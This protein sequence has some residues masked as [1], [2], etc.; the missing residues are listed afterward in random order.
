MAIYERVGIDNLFHDPGIDNLWSLPSKPRREIESSADLTPKE[1]D[2]LTEF[3]ETKINIAPSSDIVRHFSKEI[4]AKLEFANEPG[5]F[6]VMETQLEILLSKKQQK[7]TYERLMAYFSSEKA[8]T[9][10]KIPDYIESEDWDLYYWMLYERS[11]DRFVLMYADLEK[12]KKV[13]REVGRILDDARPGEIFPELLDETKKALT[14]SC[15]EA[16]KTLNTKNIKTIFKDTNFVLAKA[17]PRSDELW[18]RA[19][20]S[21]LARRILNG[22]QFDKDIEGQKVLYV[23]YNLVLECVNEKFE[24]I[25]PLLRERGY[26]AK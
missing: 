15:S 21:L 25:V 2:E 13:R 1:L 4:K 23:S 22:F 9:M 10:P 19:I 12:A 20:K 26:L 8:I 11:R 3:L 14:D 5:A 17:D 7:G 16:I 6:K 24:K 18:P